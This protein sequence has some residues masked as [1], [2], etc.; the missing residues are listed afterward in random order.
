ML[1]FTVPHGISLVMSKLP[2]PVFK[3]SYTIDALPS[4]NGSIGY[5]YTSR[6]LDVDTSAT[7]DFKETLNSVRSSKPLTSY[8]PENT[9]G[10]DIVRGAVMYPADL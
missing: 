1:D 5:L 6:P 3:P 8:R 10:T 7:V 4:L 2:S 9:Q